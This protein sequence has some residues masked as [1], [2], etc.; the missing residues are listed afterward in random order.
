LASLLFL[1]SGCLAESA[2]TTQTEQDLFDKSETFG[3][4]DATDVNEQSISDPNIRLHSSSIT[5]DGKVDSLSPSSALLDRLRTAAEQATDPQSRNYDASAAQSYW[6]VLG[7]KRTKVTKTEQ[8]PFHAIGKLG[9]GCTG[10]LVGPRYVL[11]AAHCV[12]SLKS[13]KFYLNL[14]FYPGRNGETVIPFGKIRWSKVIAP[15]EWTKGHNSDFD[16]AIVK[17]NQADMYGKILSW[18]TYGV[19]DDSLLPQSW[20]NLAGYPGEKQ[21]YSLM[22]YQPCK[23]QIVT[24]KKLFHDCDT[25]PGNSGSPIWKYY[26][27]NG[28]RIIVGIHTNGVAP[29]TK[30]NGGT[31]ITREVYE[32]ILAWQEE[33]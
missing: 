2:E 28:A 7:D 6:D 33:D 12:Y 9:N 29:G 23:L 14:N 15:K 31:R 17:L 20:V 1:W 32:R 22:W 3:A 13:D 30:F 8:F 11:T 25:T 26:P 10:A 18:L 27:N 16:F 5:P 19:V 4:P 21:P 24:E